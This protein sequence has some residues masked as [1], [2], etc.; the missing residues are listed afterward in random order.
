MEVMNNNTNIKL[1]H[2]NANIRID[3]LKRRMADL[4]EMFERMSRAL[5]YLQDRVE[6]LEN[7]MTVRQGHYV[8]V[9]DIERRLGEVEDLLKYRELLQYHALKLDAEIE[10]DRVKN[11]QI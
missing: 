3:A 7:K 4:Q 1:V 8:R 2:A 11:K 10:F 6:I 9:R 5:I